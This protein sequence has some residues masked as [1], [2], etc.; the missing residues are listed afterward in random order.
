MKPNW[1]RGLSDTIR[2]ALDTRMLR[3]MPDQGR[4]PGCLQSDGNLYTTDIHVVASLGP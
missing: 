1:W 4:E 3:G 2:S